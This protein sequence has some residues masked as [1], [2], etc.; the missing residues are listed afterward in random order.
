MIFH[1]WPFMKY[2][3]FANYIIVAQA[4]EVESTWV[5]T[6]WS[7]TSAPTGKDSKI[8]LEYWHSWCIVPQTERNSQ[9]IKILTSSSFLWVKQ[10]LMT[11]VLLLCWK[12]S[13]MIYIFLG[14]YPH[15]SIILFKNMFFYNIGQIYK[16]YTCI[17]EVKFWTAQCFSNNKIHATNVCL[18]V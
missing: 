10:W 7:W 14:Y 17:Y 2:L 1:I 18:Q 16:V 11:T 8:C 13:N 12:M 3:N 5:S 15:S 9:N 4:V 6:Q